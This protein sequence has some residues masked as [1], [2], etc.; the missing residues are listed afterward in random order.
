[1]YIYIQKTEQTLL[2]IIAGYRPEKISEASR[3]KYQHLS[4]YPSIYLVISEGAWPSG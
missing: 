3:V 4:I 2:E 1:M